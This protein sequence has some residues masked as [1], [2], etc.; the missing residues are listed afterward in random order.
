M[1]RHIPQQVLWREKVGWWGWGGGGIHL[2]DVAQVW[3]VPL[4][5]TITHRKAAAMSHLAG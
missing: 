3:T 4:T 2:S 5:F 1:V